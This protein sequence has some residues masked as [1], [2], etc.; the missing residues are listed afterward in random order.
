M[1]AENDNVAQGSPFW[2]FSLGFYRQPGVGDVCIA[3]QDTCGVDVNLLL[4][5]LWRAST[6]N[7]LSTSDVKQIDDQMRGWRDLTVIPLR[8]MRR[9]LKDNEPFVAVGSAEIFRARIKAAELEAERLQQETLYEL[10]NSTKLGVDD[11]SAE[12]AARANM[13]AY[14]TA[15]AR[16]FPRG[17]VDILLG[18]LRKAGHV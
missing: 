18:A 15:L 8:A 10:V 17:A 9:K 1:S 2:R 11:A 7:R 16:E 13:A 3:L 6:K 12:D 5:L 4:F 14:Q